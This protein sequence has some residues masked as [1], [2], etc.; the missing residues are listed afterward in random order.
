MSPEAFWNKVNKTDGCW[1]WT[2]HR[3]TNGYGRLHFDGRGIQA[4]RLAWEWTN[5][6]IPE[7][8]RVCHRCDVPNCVNPEHL[9]LGTQQDNIRDMYAKGRFP[10]YP[11]YGEYGTAAKLTWPLVYKIR[12]RYAAGGVTYTSL[13]REFGMHQSAIGKAIR[14]E[15]WAAR[16]QS[17]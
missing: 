10:K 1:L 6:P 2:G 11:R 14:G 5:G 12:E 15:T 17:W 7:G 16:E 8:L 4:H 9:F 13:G 3:T